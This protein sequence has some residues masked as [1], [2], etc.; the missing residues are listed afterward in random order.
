MHRAHQMC[1]T[2]PPIHLSPLVL[3]NPQLPLK[4]SSCR[5]FLNNKLSQTLSQKKAKFLK[6]L[7]MFGKTVLAP[8]AANAKWSEGETLGRATFLTPLSTWS[9]ICVLRGELSAELEIP[10]VGTLRQHSRIRT[11]HQI[12]LCNTL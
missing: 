11:L 9:N 7:T 8:K 3:V 10:D 2:G 5:S 4:S 12:V 6:L 1:L